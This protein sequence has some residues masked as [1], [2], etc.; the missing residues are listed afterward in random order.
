MPYYLKLR[1]RKKGPKQLEQERNGPYG[2]SSGG[3]SR[4]SGIRGSILRRSTIVLPWVSRN[5]HRVAARISGNMSRGSYPLQAAI[6]W[7]TR[8]RSSS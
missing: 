4:G 2:G 6:V 7:T 3:Q 8:F 1:I 5:S